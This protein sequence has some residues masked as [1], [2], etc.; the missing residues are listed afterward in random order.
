M[1]EKWHECVYCGK[2]LSSYKSLWQHKKNCKS[3]NKDIFKSPSPTDGSKSGSKSELKVTP[4]NMD[5]INKIVNGE[6][7]NPE[8]PKV[9][10]NTPHKQFAE[11][12]K[13]Y[14][15]NP[16]EKISDEPPKKVKKISE[17]V[18]RT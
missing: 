14:M 5:L 9:K 17:N 8:M 3:K 4:C 10:R 16:K 18:F 12:A 11:V 7:F 2:K 6:L 1:S 15:P 13:L